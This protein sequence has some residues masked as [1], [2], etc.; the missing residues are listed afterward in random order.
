MSVLAIQLPVELLQRI[1]SFLPEIPP[2]AQKSW[3]KSVE[4]ALAPP[5]PATVTN[6]DHVEARRGWAKA[7]FICRYWRAA[8][9]AMNRTI[10]IRV[11][12]DEAN[13]HI[14]RGVST[15]FA[16]S[17]VVL[18]IEQHLLEMCGF[19]YGEP[20]YISQ[21]WQQGE[22]PS[23]EPMLRFVGALGERVRGIYIYLS[24]TAN[25]TGE[26]AMT[27]N[28]QEFLK[29]APKLLPSFDELHFI[30][31]GRNYRHGAQSKPILTDG[32]FDFRGHLLATRELKVLELRDCHFDD[33]EPI[34]VRTSLRK[35]TLV[36][37][38]DS[39][40]LPFTANLKQLEYLCL[41][42]ESIPRLSTIAKMDIVEMN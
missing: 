3:K 9:L 2:V 33:P 37:S 35:L 39:W 25:R 13:K 7:A 27:R 26:V 32:T 14:R 31:P 34:F 1:F 10:P 15:V 11:A 12:P 23:A 18:H 22:G 29:L 24:K 42:L 4:Y 41:T 38:I 6:R 40:P 8:A 19:G 20:Q 5:L 16:P 36:A 17:P 30:A 21:Y 28:L